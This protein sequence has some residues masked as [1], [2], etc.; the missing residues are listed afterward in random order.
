MFATSFETIERETRTQLAGM[1]SG[2]GFDPAR[3]IEA[4]TVNRWAH[5]Y[6]GWYSPLSDP[7]YEPDT[8]PHVMWR[9][10]FG[11]IA[12]ANADA[13]ANSSIETAIDQAHRAIGELNRFR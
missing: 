2:G 6:S 12:I 8:Y 11:G 10:P 7:E 5:G 13:G 1:L 4:I 9:K 3:D